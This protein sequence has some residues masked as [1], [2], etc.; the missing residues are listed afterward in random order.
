MHIQ[1][2][3]FMHFVILNVPFHLK[4]KVKLNATENQMKVDAFFL[5]VDWCWR[6][7]IIFIGVYFSK[8]GF[9]TCNLVSWDFTTF[10]QYSPHV[11][12]SILKLAVVVHLSYAIVYPEAGFSGKK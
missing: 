8:N 6:F 5:S 11:L 4:L 2:S 12:T 1:I 9:L 10:F 3:K 7:V